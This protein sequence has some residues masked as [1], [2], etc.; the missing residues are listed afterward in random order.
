MSSKGPKGD[1]NKSPADIIIHMLSFVEPKDITNLAQVDKY[2]SKITGK[3]IVWKQ[4][5]QKYFPY[6]E[7]QS[8]IIIKQENFKEAFIKEYIRFLAIA[9]I[10]N[11]EMKWV[12]MALSGD[13]DGIQ[14]ATWIPKPT[15]D[16]TIVSEKLRQEWNE[17]RRQRLIRSLAYIAFANGHYKAVSLLLSTSF[18]QAFEIAGENGDIDVINKM[19][20][21]CREALTESPYL[22]S[23]MSGNLLEAF[24]SAVKAGHLDVVK[25]LIIP[26][27]D[28]VR[29]DSSVMLTLRSAYKSALKEKHPDVIEF[30]ETRIDKSTRQ[31]YL[32]EVYTEALE[33]KNNDVAEFVKSRLNPKILESY[34]KSQSDNEPHALV[35]PSNRDPHRDRHPKGRDPYPRG[36]RRR[37]GPV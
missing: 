1:F 29:I 20:M 15:S 17:E 26:C 25:E 6:L 8:K 13:L 7:K 35:P 5:V 4:L 12:L 3:D 21:A 31:K 32:Q 24:D 9:R 18:N 10:D 30:L 23:M 19:N 11:C 22:D 28:N 36:G 27:V 16:K 34:K 2:F 37:H 14:K 33:N